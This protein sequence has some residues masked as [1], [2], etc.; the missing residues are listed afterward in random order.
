IEYLQNHT[1]KALALIQEAVS[2]DPTNLYYGVREMLYLGLN[3]RFEEADDI[4]KTILKQQG[5]YHR[6]HQYRGEYLFETD[7]KVSACESMMKAIEL[8]GCPDV[9]KYF[10]CFESIKDITQC[11]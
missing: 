2:L 3:N 7:D 8:N 11:F 9:T 10:T 6:L 1:V 5:N 4:Y